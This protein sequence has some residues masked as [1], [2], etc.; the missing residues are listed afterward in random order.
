MPLLEERYRRSRPDPRHAHAIEPHQ[1]PCAWRIHPA[2][3]ET[4]EHHLL[5]VSDEGGVR[6]VLVSSC[7][8]GFL[9]LEAGRIRVETQ[10]VRLRHLFFFSAFSR[11]NP[12][13]LIV[14]LSDSGTAEGSFFWDD[15][16]GIGKEEPWKP[17]QPSQLLLLTGVE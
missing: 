8:L 10:A 15:G 1:P 4:G 14:A 6:Q 17:L 9:Q 7:S 12:L 13:G 2:L 3:A 11:K 16:E 5:Q